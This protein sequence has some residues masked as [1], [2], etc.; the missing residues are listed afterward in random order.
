MVFVKSIQLNQIFLGV[1][2]LSKKI[3]NERKYFVMVVGMKIEYN[4]DVVLI[5]YKSETMSYDV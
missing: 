2:Q 1:S 4:S 5:T 3:Y